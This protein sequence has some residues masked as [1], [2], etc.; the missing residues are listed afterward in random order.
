MSGVPV[1]LQQLLRT[2]PDGDE[3]PVAIGRWSSG[4]YFLRLSAA[5]GRIGFA[6]FVVR[7]GRLGE[8]RVAVVL[9]TQTWQ[10]YNF[11][12]DDGDGI[13]D[14]WYAQLEGLT[15]LGSLDRSWTEASPPHYQPLRRSLPPLARQAPTSRPT[16]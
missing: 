7:P 15:P 5:D 1:G 3:I 10:A 9:P 16:S 6:P 12:D 2:P 11:W 8:H 13:G 4:L 14:T